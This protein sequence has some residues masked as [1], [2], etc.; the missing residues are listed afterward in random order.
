M[1]IT[2]Q[3]QI[4]PSKRQEV[5]LLQACGVSRQAWNIMLQRSINAYE[6]WSRGELE[7]KP[8]VSKYALRKEYTKI[9]KLL[10]PYTYK[11]SKH[12]GDHSLYALGD[13][14]KRFF[15]SISNF[16]KFKRKKHGVGSYTM[17]GGPKSDYSFQD[18]KLKVPGFK[19]LGLIRTSQKPR[20]KG[21]IC[22]VTISQRAGKWY[23]AISYEISGETPLIPSK[24]K[25]GVVGVDLGIKELAV[26]SDGT[27]FENPRT[28]A[29]SQ[30]KIRK[31][32]KSL[33]RK[34]KGSRNWKKQLLRLQKAHKRIAN[35]R[36][37]H[38]HNLSSHL[39]KTYNKVVI[40]DLNVSGMSRN[41]KLSKHILDAGFY[42]LRRQLDYKCKIY[43]TELV[44][45]D[46]FYPSSKLCSRCGHKK[47]KLSLSERTYSCERCF[48]NIDRDLNAALNLMAY[49]ICATA[50]GEE[51]S[52]FDSIIGTKLSFMKQES[53]TIEA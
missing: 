16:P 6:C 51:S 49:D 45:A 18:R 43:G 7:E 48:L 40:E 8:D 35:I 46:R 41:R 10:L 37:W 1:Y 53:G 50:C 31:E 19:K 36:K 23:A 15:K 11:V 9:R 30:K 4:V 24:N 44:V 2:Q 13:A 12:A 33:S 20:F 22:K 28:Y 34:V 25:S 39:A 26:L 5:Y 47:E 3:V 32:N 29:K 42:E 14:Y 27:V 38:L 17:S 52:G 21:K